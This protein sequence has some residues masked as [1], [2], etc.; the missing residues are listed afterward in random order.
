M[1]CESELYEAKAVGRKG[2][3]DGIRTGAGVDW[4]KECGLMRGVGEHT[5]FAGD[6]ELGI[7]EFTQLELRPM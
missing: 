3:R 2:N 4:F 6:E 7:S 1:N 5:F